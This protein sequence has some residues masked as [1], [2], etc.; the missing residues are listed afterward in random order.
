MLKRDCNAVRSR[1][2]SYSHFSVISGILA[3][4]TLAVVPGTV[5][6]LLGLLMFSISTPPDERR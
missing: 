2:G 4:T 1:S 5:L 6:P 3:L